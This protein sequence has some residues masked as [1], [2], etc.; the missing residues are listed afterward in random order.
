MNFPSY[1]DKEDIDWFYNDS[2]F[3]DNFDIFISRLL[4]HPSSKDIF[5]SIFIAAKNVDFSWGFFLD[6]CFFAF[7]TDKANF[8][9]KK[10]MDER[11]EKII[12]ASKNVINLVCNSKEDNPMWI[13]AH[14]IHYEEPFE[15]FNVDLSI[16][17]EEDKPVAEVLNFMAHNGIA[18]TDLMALLV[19]TVENTKYQNTPVVSQPNRKNVE[20]INFCREMVS[21]FRNKLQRPLF[22]VVASLVN[23]LYEIDYDVQDVRDSVRGYIDER[24]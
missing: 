8:R 16:F 23:A 7:S 14:S 9:T 20:V 19:K 10:E 21:F 2:S 17:N 22:S 12:S 3:K 24:W 15:F 6:Y 5:D 4:G 11:S 18:I 1:V 13:M